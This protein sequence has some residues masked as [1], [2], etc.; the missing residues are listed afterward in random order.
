MQH[1]AHYG[2]KKDILAMG[3]I[4]T[5]GGVNPWS[6]LEVLAM[7]TQAIHNALDSLT[8][9]V[10]MERAK[11]YHSL[12]YYDLAA[13]DVYRAISLAENSATEDE[14]GGSDTD[15]EMFDMYYFLIDCLRMCCCTRDVWD[16]LRAASQYAKTDWSRTRVGYIKDYLNATCFQAREFTG[17]SFGELFDPS[18]DYF[19]PESLSSR[20]H[21]RRE[22][23]QWNSHEPDRSGASTLRMLNERLSKTA[24]KCEV[25]TA[26]LPKMH[27]D[28]RSSRETSTQ[29]GLFAK[30]DILPGETILQETSVLTSTNRAHSNLCDACRGPLPD[31]DGGDS[32]PK[33]C[34]DCFDAVYCS[35][36]CRTLAV[37]TYHPAVCGMEGLAGIG[38]NN[39]TSLDYDDSLYLNLVA[40]AI[41]MAETQGIHPLDLPE[42]KYLWGDFNPYDLFMDRSMSLPQKHMPFSFRMNIVQP[43]RILEEMELDPFKMLPKYDTWVINTLYAKFRAVAPARQST[44]DG[45]SEVAVVHPLWCLANH[46]CNPNVQWECEGDIKFIARA[47]RIRWGDRTEEECEGRIKVGEQVLN[48]YCDI[49][50]GFKERRQWARAALGG[51][52]QC[53][54]CVWEEGHEGNYEP[55]ER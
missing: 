35:E 46:S 29:L 9:A 27:G 38:T 41:A 40:R 7:K 42:V 33:Q 53:E 10:F 16:L 47:K 4:R 51:V 20:G 23:Y 22:V 50:L 25:R 17:P 2:W 11:A 13:A 3:S 52:C 37:E 18:Q 36:R 15:A 19:K 31:L 24:P 49:K 43:T 21:A 48:H 30:E 34:E 54:R 8:P 32:S 26:E 28:D 44:W 39:S 45:L 1:Q 5:G 6:P 12:R 14:L 55:P